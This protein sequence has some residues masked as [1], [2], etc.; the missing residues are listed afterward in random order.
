MPTLFNS[1]TV[2]LLGYR[3]PTVVEAR[4]L[5]YSI[6]D[7]KSLDAG[8]EDIRFIY[9]KQ[10]RNN[11]EYKKAIDVIKSGI[12][13]Y[14][15]KSRPRDRDMPEEARTLIQ[16][17]SKTIIQEYEK[18]VWDKLKNDFSHYNEALVTLLN[19]EEEYYIPPRSDL[20]NRDES[21]PRAVA[22]SR[23]LDYL[24]RHNEDHDGRIFVVSAHAGVGKT[25][26]SRWLARDLALHH[27][28]IPLYLDS[29][30]WAG[31]NFEKLDEDL[32]TL[33]KQATEIDL[34]PKRIELALK[35]GY[36]CLILDGL[37]ELCG[38]GK[39]QFDPNTTLDALAGV[40]GD[41]GSEARP[42]EAR[43]LLTTRRLFL[44]LG[45]TESPGNADIVQ[46]YPFD[47]QQAED[48]VTRR[49]GSSSAQAREAKKLY[50]HLAGGHDRSQL[51][52]LPLLVSTLC[53]HV[54]DCEAGMGE[55]GGYGFPAN[56]ADPLHSLLLK[57]CDR[58][59]ER[60]KLQTNH[61]Q[62]LL[63][64]RE[65]AVEHPQDVNPTFQASDVCVCGFLEEDLT[66]LA[67]HHLLRHES[68]ENLRFAYEFLGPYLRA[69]AVVEFL[70]EGTIDLKQ[71]LTTL[72]SNDMEASGH[73]YEQTLSML[74]D[75]T[76][77]DLI[78]TNIASL[79]KVLDAKQD[80]KARS[81]LFHLL[82]GLL[83]L[84]EDPGRLFELT[85]GEPFLQHRIVQ[86]LQLWGK[87]EGLD[88][89]QVR[90]NK[91]RFTDLQLKNC[92]VDAKTSFIECEFRGT[93]SVQPDGGWKHVKVENCQ[94][95]DEADAALASL[96]GLG[97][98]DPEK[99]AQVVLDAVVEKLRRIRRVLEEE[100]WNQ[101][102]LRRLDKAGLAMEA[103][104]AAELIEKERSGRGIVVKDRQAFAA[105][106][107]NRQI[108]GSLRKFRDRLVE[109]LS[110]QAS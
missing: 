102:K 2:T 40:V 47:R 76:D 62:Q 13:T 30:Q 29:K 6:F 36:M 48:Y 33:I 110:K 82:A 12:K 65:L 39:G 84:K 67:T 63:A 59:V 61:E 66:H 10:G 78:C 88:L 103:A 45:I 51:I 98:V 57:I 43:V 100:K 71:N 27:D 38:Y 79:Y 23:A 32:F 5:A 55:E 73:L 91:C 16:H 9:L 101:G 34:S 17:A 19:G 41:L 25:T 1:D 97:V 3:K 21:P 68:K 109:I 54:A 106:V 89:S 28:V 26:F 108:T 85:V 35:Q 4:D 49:F 81:F 53:N 96:K 7:T 105:Y 75:H 95:S 56:S 90:F 77:K 8:A 46:L 92:R 37:D 20:D 80:A 93:L 31:I 50:N 44:D 74:L 52:N 15:V 11:E 18:L 99:T 83:N 104:I 58:E 14:I 70:R 24:T 42:S 60:Q 87:F 22:A 94:N 72:M 107:N 64:F 69:L 86:N